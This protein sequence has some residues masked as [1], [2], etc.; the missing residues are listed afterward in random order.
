MFILKTELF[1]F[2]KETIEWMKM[3]EEKYN[4][5]L[6]LNEPGTG[7]T[8]CCLGLIAGSDSIGRNL[9][10][11]PAGLVGNWKAEINKHTNCSIPILDWEASC[12]SRTPASITIV[13]YTTLAKR[14][15]ADGSSADGI[16]WCTFD[17]IILDEGHYIRNTNTKIYKTVMKLLA[18]NK[19]ILT[20]TPIFN[21]KDDL[22]AYFS[23][24]QLKS[25]GE[26]HSLGEWNKLFQ[27]S[28][29]CM[30]KLSQF[31]KEHSITKKKIDVDCKFVDKKENVINL[32]FSKE[33][34]EFYDAFKDYSIERLERL[35]N[36]T[37]GNGVHLKKIVSCN[38]LSYI[39]RLKQ[40]CN[41]PELVFESSKAF[42]SFNIKTTSDLKYYNKSKCIEE[43]CP[44]CYECKSDVLIDCGHKFCKSCYEKMIHVKINKCPI[45]RGYTMNTP[46][47]NV[48]ADANANDNDNVNP[49]PFEKHKFQSTKIIK[50]ME[51]V[52]DTISRGEKIVIVSQWTSMLDIVEKTF[53]DTKLKLSKLNGKMSP[54][55]RERSIK[56]FNYNGNCNVMLLSLLSSAEGINLTGANN[57]VILDQW[58]NNSKMIQVA[59]RIH[60]IGQT[61]SVN[62][63]RLQIG[64]DTR[65]NCNDTRGNCNDP[66]IES[67]EELINKLVNRKKKVSKML[68][69]PWKDK[70]NNL[71]YPRFSLFK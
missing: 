23:F 56:E 10:V 63:T 4:G 47:Y 12:A 5:G 13:S 43:E 61:K 25:V 16:V 45:C 18:K 33:E 9:I 26:F 27:N 37:R 59:D 24:L 22:Y 41:H 50:L 20:A 21:S 11:C 71:E 30:M 49:A 60:R 40:C 36:L 15:S 29:I 34:R 35:S 57:M 67:I 7:K 54:K 52:K 6:L 65:G 17:R 53:S 28:P 31:L 48:N 69:K 8:I 42:R 46:T 62:I 51:I 3:R 58:W 64:N 39:L 38:I 55:E 68:T 19:W 32:T 70:W 2:Q 14:T 44:I 1:G 66:Q